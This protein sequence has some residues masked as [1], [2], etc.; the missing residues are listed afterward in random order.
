[1]KEISDEARKLYDE[2]F[3]ISDM[4]QV[5]EDIQRHMDAYHEAKS[6]TETAIRA[7]LE[8]QVLEYE[9]KAKE[10]K[11][12]KNLYNYRSAFTPGELDKV[13]DEAKST[14]DAHDS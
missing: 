8:R 11:T 3:P 2:L 6:L 13:L 9:A 7:R 5:L 14:L 12:L 4:P 10:V 1:M